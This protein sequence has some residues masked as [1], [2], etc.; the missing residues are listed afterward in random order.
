MS[1]TQPRPDCSADPDHDPATDDLLALLAA[2][3][4]GTILQAIRTEPKPARQLADECDASRPT[5]YRRLN[6]LESAGLVDSTMTYDAD[7]HHR[8]VFEATMESLSIEVTA[9][10][11]SVSVTTTE[12][13]T[14]SSGS[15]PVES[16]S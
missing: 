11:L 9:E 7:G 4:T 10:G 8:T 15:T 6:R 2:E 14:T 3:H 5:V 12:P 16:T 1:S 13:D